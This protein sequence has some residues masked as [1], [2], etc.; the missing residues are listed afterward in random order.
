MLN[1]N[2]MNNSVESKKDSG[3]DGV[4][5]GKEKDCGTNM[6]ERR[7]WGAMMITVVERKATVYLMI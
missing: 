6:V 4:G 1:D 5:R 3:S 2:G 7:K